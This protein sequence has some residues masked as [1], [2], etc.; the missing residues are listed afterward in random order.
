MDLL[1]IIQR[2]MSFESFTLEIVDPG[3]TT[4]F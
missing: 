3:F 4:H 2:E 1:T